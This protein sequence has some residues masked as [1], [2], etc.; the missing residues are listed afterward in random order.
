MLSIVVT[1]FSNETSAKEFARKLLE[2]KLAVCVQLSHIT[3]FY[4]W[5]DSCMEEPEVR[6]VIKVKKSL[7]PL[8]A[9]FFNDNH[10]YDVPQLIEIEASSVAESYLN[11]AMEN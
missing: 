10:P 2:N 8:L 3:S 1:T 4:N 5:Q 11:W 9:Q 6:M 7:M